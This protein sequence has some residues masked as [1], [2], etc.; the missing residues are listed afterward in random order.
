MLWHYVQ[1]GQSQGPVTE[2]Q[3]KAM[4]TS[5]TLRPSD[6]VW[7][8][9]MAGWTAIQAV[10]ELQPAPVL[11]ALEPNPYVAPQT[12]VK[13]P[14]QAEMQSAGPVSAE[15]VEL[16]RKT[17]PWVRFF[18]VLGIFGILLMALG[19][20]AMFLLNIGPL[21]T[22]PLAARI[23]MSALYIVLACLYGPPIL[24][25]HRYASRIRNLMDENSSQ[26]LE[27][28]LR[29]QKSFWKYIGIFTAIT[30]CIYILVMI[31]VLITSLVMGLGNRL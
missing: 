26:N 27:H 9:G 24:F 14:R 30:M 11:I 10:P 18:S 5:D 4:L 12:N 25:L 20:A 3:L 19:A 17:K 6:L 31:G 7:H 28:A 1:N 8:E 13:P 23:G 21:R 22:L 16:L 15:A 29:A 2:A